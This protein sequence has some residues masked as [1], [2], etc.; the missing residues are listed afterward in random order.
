MKQTFT[1]SDYISGL[2]CDKLLHLKTH[3]PGLREEQEARAIIEQ[4]LLFEQTAGRLLFPDG[5]DM[6]RKSFVIEEHLE[7]T[8][9][10]LQ[11][12]DCVIFQAA[13]RT[14]HGEISIC[15]AIVK[16]GDTIEIYEMKATSQLLDLH[17][18]DVA[19]Q[20][21]VLTAAGVK[22]DKAFLVHVN[23]EYVRDGELTADFIKVEDATKGVVR[24]QS[25]IPKKI[26][27]HKAITRMKST[28]E[29][30]I[31]HHCL[32]YKLPACPFQKHCFS[33][34]PS[35]N[36]FEV[37]SM[38]TSKKLGLYYQG[39]QTIEQLA[40]SNTKLT[41]GQMIQVSCELEDSMAT[42]PDLLGNW[43][44]PLSRETEL[45][46]LDFE[47]LS[48]CVPYDGW[49]SYAQAP[50][51]YSLHCRTQCGDISH[52]EYLADAH[53][54]DSRREF[55]ERLLSD[56][57]NYESTS[58]IVVY[59]ASFE[60]SVLRNLA[61]LYPDLDVRIKSII[62]R[63]VDL[64]EVFKEKWY[65][66][67][68]F[69]GSYSIKAVLPVLCPELSYGELTIGNGSV[70]SYEFFKMP[71]YDDAKT[72]EVRQALLDYCRTDTL[73]MVRIFEY[74]QKFLN[75]NIPTNRVA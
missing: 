58:P 22:V 56:I 19:F 42:R 45:L 9:S 69:K 4:G 17:Y 10:E 64:M 11:K 72:A 34:L 1:K 30:D 12:E 13:F 8:T 25:M 29:V 16:R 60:S 36:I 14:A 5:L 63:I 54:E 15:D 46:F 44:S 33:G 26:A 65:Y 7:R 61:K 73:A 67:K 18:H 21:Y 52:H 53:K 27:R 48:R 71:E 43:L 38:R 3:H 41:D 59:N 28:P 75:E 37:R 74:L 20:W 35:G 68:R 62:T 50:F 51:Q 66:D 2:R 70:A 57:E 40:A 23:K 6:S 32:D 31:G 55:V 47:T 24:I 49:K 39:I